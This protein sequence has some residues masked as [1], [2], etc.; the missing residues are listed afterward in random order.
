MRN[1]RDHQIR[2]SVAATQGTSEDEKENAQ[3]IQDCGVSTSSALREHGFLPRAQSMRCEHA[4]V[5]RIAKTAL[6]PKC[7][8]VWTTP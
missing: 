7:N 3:K 2:N 5:T 4:T 6:V 8:V 1:V